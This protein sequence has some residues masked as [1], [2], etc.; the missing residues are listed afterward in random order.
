MRLQGLGQGEGVRG[1]GGHREGWGGAP[2][3]HKA[4][5]VQAVQVLSDC[6]R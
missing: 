5:Y 6:M 4:L 3:I 1:G 2:R